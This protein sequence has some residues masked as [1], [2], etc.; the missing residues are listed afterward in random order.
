M[1]AHQ[2]GDHPGQPLGEPD[3]PEADGGQPGEDTGKEN[4]AHHLRHAIDEA[5]PGIAAAIENAPGHID[6]AQE[7]IEEACKNANIHDFIVSLPDGY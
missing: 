1:D 3:A 2:A 4:P 5:E 7:E 6:H